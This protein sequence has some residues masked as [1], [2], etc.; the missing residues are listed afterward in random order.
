MA[1]F[2]GTN[3]SRVWTVAGSRGSSAALI[4]TKAYR[5]DV[6]KLRLSDLD[7]KAQRCVMRVG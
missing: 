4:L 6:H 3:V 1:K 5:L 2:C 7:E